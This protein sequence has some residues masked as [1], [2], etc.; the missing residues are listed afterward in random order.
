V[1][2]YRP[3]RLGLQPGRD[4]PSSGAVHYQTAKGARLNLDAL[5][6]IALVTQHVPE[7]GEHTRHYFGHYSNAARGKRRQRAAQ[8]SA[9]HPP[10]D[11][12][13]SETEDFRRECRRTWARL[14]QK[15]YEVDPLLCPDC[16]GRLEVIAFIN[17]PSR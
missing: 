6:W 7:P 1:R 8:D 12:G 5:E 9:A 16:G 10:A 2:L 14:I 4:D 13:D 17:A 11:S 3:R 15:V